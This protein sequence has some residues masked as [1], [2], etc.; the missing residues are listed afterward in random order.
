MPLVHV[1]RHRLRRLLVAHRLAAC[2]IALAIPLAII[3]RLIRAKSVARS[4]FRRWT[5][6]AATSIH[7]I[8]ARYQ[9][10]LTE[11]S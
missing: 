4:Y 1:A 6:D 9:S 2:V 10:Q 8:A 5:H 7:P 11:S 3:S